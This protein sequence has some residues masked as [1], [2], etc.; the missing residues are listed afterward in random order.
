MPIAGKYIYRQKGASQFAISR[1]LEYYHDI[2][3]LRCFNKVLR[4]L[5]ECQIYHQCSKSLSQY[6]QGVS[7]ASLAVGRCQ[8]LGLKPMLQK[9]NQSVNTSYQND[10]ALVPAMNTNNRC[11]QF[12]IRNATMFIAII[13]AALRRSVKSR[14]FQFLAL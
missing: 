12:I 7:C 10:D 5:R 3:Q 11:T 14:H 1:A 4:L 8:L 2:R 6:R 9:S 13:P